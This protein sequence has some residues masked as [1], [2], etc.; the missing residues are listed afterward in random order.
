MVK[1][2]TTDIYKNT[3]IDYIYHLGD[4]H[5]PNDNARHNEYREVFELLYAKLKNNKKTNS[6][7]VIAGDIIDKGDKI[8]PDCINLVKEFFLNLSNIFPTVIIAGNHDDNVRGN[9][10]KTDSITAILKDNH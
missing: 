5:I 4:I 7:I 8:T 3:N 10:T 1:V 2:I 6:L 9:D